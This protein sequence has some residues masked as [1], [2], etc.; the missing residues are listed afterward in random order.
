MR[1][2]KQAQ[3]HKVFHGVQA[4]RTAAEDAQ[5]QLLELQ[6]A[7]GLRDVKARASQADYW[8]SKFEASLAQAARE[9]NAA[10]LKVQRGAARACGQGSILTRL[11][12]VAGRAV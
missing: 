7:A 4:A 8:R 10:A 3:A 11:D 5:R 1:L 2:R 6:S 12:F 9:R